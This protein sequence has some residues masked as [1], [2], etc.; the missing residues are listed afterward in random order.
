MLWI[1]W[2]VKDRIRIQVEIAAEE[3]VKQEELTGVKKFYEL[4]YDENEGGFPLNIM[5]LC[6]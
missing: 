1:K 6:K 5:I 3:F 4:D 2:N